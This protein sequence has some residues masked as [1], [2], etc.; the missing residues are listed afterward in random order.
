MQKVIGEA[1][2]VRI[3]YLAVCDPLT[4]EPLTH[5]DREAVILSA[6]R[7]GSVRLIDNV[8]ARRKKR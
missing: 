6:V 4:L 7:L 8:H 3:D 5:I 1:P 2:A